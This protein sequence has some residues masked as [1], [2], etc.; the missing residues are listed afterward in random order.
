[1]PLDTCGPRYFESSLTQHRFYRF[2]FLLVVWFTMTFYG[3]V[4]GFGWRRPNVCVYV[5]FKK[6][7]LKE[8][9]RSNVVTW[10]W[11]WSLLGFHLKLK[12][13]VGVGV[14]IQVCIGQMEGIRSGLCGVLMWV[15][16]QCMWPSWPSL[17]VFSDFIMCLCRVY[18]LTCEVVVLV[19][20]FFSFGPLLLRLQT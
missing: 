2:L 20:N 6:Q 4:K 15:L 16:Q 13:S 12:I 5:R 14:L 10:L 7:H 19:D 9:W 3:P 1:M 11:V 17:L 18:E 8:V